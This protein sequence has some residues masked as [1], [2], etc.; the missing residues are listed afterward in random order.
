MVA[1]VPREEV[2]GASGGRLEPGVVL[3]ELLCNLRPFNGT[4]YE[5]KK[6]VLP[7]S[8]KRPQWRS[9]SSQHQRP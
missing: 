7:V 4:I 8:L 6:Q 9:P 5:I 2:R 3:Y 1:Y